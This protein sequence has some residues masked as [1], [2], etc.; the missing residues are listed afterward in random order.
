MVYPCS[1]CDCVTQVT[2]GPIQ[3]KNRSGDVGVPV[4]R[5]IPPAPHRPTG[6]GA[7]ARSEPAVSELISSNSL[8]FGHGTAPAYI[9]YLALALGVYHP[10]GCPFK[11]PPTFFIDCAGSSFGWGHFELQFCV[12]HSPSTTIL[13]VGKLKMRN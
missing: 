11:Q 2:Q 8:Q 3:T 12:L 5:F 9:A 13:K 1:A 4:P 7:G 10:C 6:V